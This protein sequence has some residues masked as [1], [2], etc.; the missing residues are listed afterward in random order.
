MIKCENGSSCGCLQDA[1]FCLGW[2]ADCIPALMLFVALLPL[3]RGLNCKKLL[4][5]L[6]IKVSLDTRRVDKK[7]S[8][9]VFRLSLSPSLFLSNRAS[10]IPHH[11]LPLHRINDHLRQ[12]SVA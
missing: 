10:F 8:W 9:A 2:L 4:S 6:Q 11:L 7:K 3:I 5:V 12:N 1:V